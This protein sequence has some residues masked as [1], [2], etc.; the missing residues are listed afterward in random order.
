V[1]LQTTQG[2]A[3]CT[4]TDIEASELD[5]RSGDGID[6]TLCWNALT[7]RLFVAVRDDHGGDLIDVEVEAAEARDAFHHPYAYAHRRGS[8]TSRRP[9]ERSGLLKEGAEQ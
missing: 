8:E 9:R 1:Q 6:V 3:M 4:T 2:E 7:N 5:H